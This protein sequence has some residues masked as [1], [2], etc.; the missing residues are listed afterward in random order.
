MQAVFFHNAALTKMKDL[1][2]T[3]NL[4]PSQHS[5]LLCGGTGQSS[6]RRRGPNTHPE[7]LRGG[8]LPGAPAWP[9]VSLLLLPTAGC[10]LGLGHGCQSPESPSPDPALGG[11]PPDSSG[12]PEPS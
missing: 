3:E 11:L 10:S 2:Q 12:G 1:G 5:W 8:W 9:S 7:A 6:S 4:L